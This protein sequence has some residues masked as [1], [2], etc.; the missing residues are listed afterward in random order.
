MSRDQ[1]WGETTRGELVL[2]RNNLLHL[3]CKFYNG[4]LQ[5]NPFL[6][7]ILGQTLS[8]AQY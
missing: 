3:V 7:L 6:G 5:K 8:A 2:G 1:I 4:T